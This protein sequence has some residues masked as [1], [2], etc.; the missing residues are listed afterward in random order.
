M[1]NMIR[2]PEIRCIDEDGEALGIIRTRDALVRAH[3]A[4][5]DL[6][7][8]NATAK[9]PVCRIMDHGKF[10]YEQDKKKKEQKKRQVVVKL[11]EV[12]F[13]VNVGDHDYETKLR[14]AFE[15]LKDGHRVKFSLMFRGRENAH[16]ELGFEL[17]KRVTA[18]IAEVATVE[19][20][21]RLQGRNIFMMV[22]PK[23]N[24]K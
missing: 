2:V 5:L 18:D 6:V 17:M 19:Q 15:F 12:K 14:H 11:K 7:E 10:K 4:G 3:E 13:H 24:K 20:A 23:K 9:P 1:N 21:P 8:I 16:R 22:V